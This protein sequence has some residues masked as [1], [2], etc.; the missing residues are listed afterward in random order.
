MYGNG[1]E[2]FPG[3]EAKTERNTMKWLEGKRT[4]ELV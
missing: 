2:K 4:I 3:N 1:E